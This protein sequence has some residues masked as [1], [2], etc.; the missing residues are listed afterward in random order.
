MKAAIHFAVYAT[1][2]GA[3]YGIAWLFDLDYVALV[4][5]AALAFATAGLRC[6]AVRERLNG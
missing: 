4:A 2:S 3:C 6:G 1:I 5:F